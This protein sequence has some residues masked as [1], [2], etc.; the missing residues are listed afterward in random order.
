MRQKAHKNCC[1][2]IAQER[3]CASRQLCR[4]LGRG[5]LGVNYPIQAHVLDGTILERLGN[6]WER[7][8]VEGVDHW[9]Q[10]LSFAA[11]P[12][13]LSFICLLTVDMI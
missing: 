6:A 8:M 11:W 2:A 3:K 7:A 13:F 5:G 4:M 1:K 12:H 9:R 10:A